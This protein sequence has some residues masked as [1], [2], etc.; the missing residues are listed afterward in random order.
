M[1][2]SVEFKAP[3]FLQGVPAKQLLID[4]RWV[5]ASS[6]KTFT[7][8]DP[9][10]GNLLAT[11]AEADAA[12]VDLAVAAARRA[13]EGVWRTFKPYD[14]QVLILKLADLVEKHFEELASIETLDMGA[15]ISR[16]GS[17]KR[18]VVAQIRF[19]A[20]LT[21]AQTGQ[22][23][24]NS[25]G[26]M[27]TYTLKEP[28]GVVGAIIPWNSP[29]LFCV[30]KLVP[31]LAAGCTVVL[32]P[33]EQASLSALRFGEL[34]MEAGFP[35][36]TVNIVTGT[37]AAGAALSGHMGVD[38]VSFTGSTE[39]GQAIIR[40]SAGNVKRLAL[41]LGGKSPDIV[42]ADANLDA[43]VAGAATA[44]FA[45]SGQMCIAG[46]RLFVERKI[47]DEFVERVAAIGSKLKVGSPTDATTDLGPL[48]SGEQLDRVVGYM[49][50]GVRQGAKA[51]MG[52][53]RLTAGSL[54]KGFFVPPTL[55][56]NVNDDM[57]IA[58]EEIFGPVI[59]AIP[60]DDIDDVIRR[61]NDT[62]YGLGGGVWTQDV[63][64]AHKVAHAIRAGTVWV[65]CY[66]PLDPAVPFGGYK[67]SGYGREAGTA[68]IDE[69][70]NTKAVFMKTA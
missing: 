7:A 11:V 45:N 35:A 56:A 53:K 43:A 16:T 36:G 69:F 14:R 60:F 58:R 61:A 18:R 42:F 30:W 25:I 3:A 23:I 8:N 15:P 31:A 33:A 39:T 47:Y 63:S 32:K 51:L 54:S 64:K 22:T 24:D 70:M 52:G 57:T 41:E 62:P 40:S 29:L 55:F 12:D 68:H 28:L 17:A 26:N 50:E 20:G 27:F 13:F 10:T 2:T 37:G 9:A 67:M 34:L 1:T 65:N 48:I 59:S 6:G 19:Y 5:Q 38:K 4:G 44:V 49:D 21:T 66:L 46:S